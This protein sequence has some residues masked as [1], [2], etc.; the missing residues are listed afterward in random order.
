MLQVYLRSTLSKG[1]AE[2]LQLE[3]LENIA[4]CLQPAAAGGKGGGGTDSRQLRDRLDL[5]RAVSFARQLAAHLA[6]ELEGAV[7]GTSTAIH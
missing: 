6:K 3:T 5:F 4:S 7:G 2:I 1:R